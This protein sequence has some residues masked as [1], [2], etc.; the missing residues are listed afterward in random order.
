MPAANS[1]THRLGKR[2]GILCLVHVI[3]HLK[4]MWA[5]HYSVFIT[6]MCLS[7]IKVSKLLILLI[8]VNEVFSARVIKA[9]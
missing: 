3:L 9:N 8:V 2:Q 5:T 4:V 7:L 6:V 1:L